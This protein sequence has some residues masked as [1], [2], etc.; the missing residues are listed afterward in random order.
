[1]IQRDKMV[2]HLIRL[3]RLDKPTGIWLLMWP[4][5]WGVALAS[6]GMPNSAMLLWFALGAVALRSAGC[7]INDL[8]DRDID[9]Q[10]ART[11]DRPLA[12]GAVTPA[13]A[14]GLVIILL[15][16]GLIV[17]LNLHPNLLYW[18][19]LAIGLVVTYPFMKR[20]TWWPQLF[21]GFTFNLGALFGWIAV[22]GQ[23]DAAAW[24]LYA[25]AIC[26]TVGY[27]TIYAHQDVDDDMRISVKSTAIRFGDDSRMMIT[28]FYIGFVVLLLGC[29]ILTESG[30]I[31]Y[32][33]IACVAAHLS[34][35]LMT[36]QFNDS[37]NCLRRFRS[38]AL[39]GLILFMAIVGDH[40]I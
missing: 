1:M 35:Q 4:C 25:A 19:P 37:A 29:G 33:G 13:Q 20:I 39:P 15:L 7:V 17:L 10:V 18:S 22:H 26:W 27:D 3:M 9:K 30:P 36:V 23:P 31:Y 24:V 34:W 2:F 5:F 38:N 40:S 11:Q 16:V 8:A 32:L 14:I 21:L 28:L 6:D 12:S